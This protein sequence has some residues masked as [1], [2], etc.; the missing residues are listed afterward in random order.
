MTS[1]VW[2]MPW[3]MLETPDIWEKAIP[4][5]R[6]WIGREP[7]QDQKLYQALLEKRK[8]TP[9]QAETILQLLHNF[10]DDA[11]TAAGNV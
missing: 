2:A 3:P 7:G 10:S 5:I 11:L 6:H 9:A 1:S 4:V 8:L